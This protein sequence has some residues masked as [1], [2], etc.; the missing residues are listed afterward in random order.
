MVGHG[1]CCCIMSKC[2]QT[3]CSKLWTLSVFTLRHVF[4][5]PT[6]IWC[7]CGLYTHCVQKSTLMDVKCQ[8][9]A[10]F[11]CLQI[12]LQCTVFLAIWL[13]EIEQNR[14]LS[15]LSQLLG[16]SLLCSPNQPCHP[17][18]CAS[19]SLA[20]FPVLGSQVCASML[21]F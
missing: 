19:P 17:Q 10:I 13:P 3:V 14:P 11:L 12:R 9:W 2:L 16:W 5:L 7:V 15:S 6:P 8:K 1:A 18:N 21:G 20:V 4:F